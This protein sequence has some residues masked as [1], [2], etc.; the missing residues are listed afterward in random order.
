M[1]NKLTKVYFLIHLSD[2]LGSA[3][4]CLFDILHV[5]RSLSPINHVLMQLFCISTLGLMQ[6]LVRYS[7]GEM[8]RALRQWPCFISCHL[9]HVQ[10]MTLYLL[11]QVWSCANMQNKHLSSH[12]SKGIMMTKLLIYLVNDIHM[13]RLRKSM[14]KSLRPWWQ[15]FSTVQSSWNKKDMTQL[16]CQTEAVPGC[17]LHVIYLCMF[18]SLM[19]FLLLLWYSPQS[20]NITGKFNQRLNSP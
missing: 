11:F 10:K 3:F 20:K 5:Y 19:G 13:F 7:G 2:F 14:L 15:Q 18:C 9:S 17:S 12:S 1:L 6:G 8:R 16:L 4:L